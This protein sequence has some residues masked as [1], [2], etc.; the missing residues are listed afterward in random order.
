MSSVSM[1]GMGTG[2]DIYTMAEQMA[3]IQTSAKS[4]QLTQNETEISEEVA[5]LEELSSALNSFYN[6][7]G[8]YSD[9]DLF[10]ALTVQMAEDDKDFIDAKVDSTAVPNTY[11]LEVQQV[12]TQHKVNAISA[13]SNAA[14]VPPGQYTI[15]I[16]GEEMEIDV[17]AGQNSFGEVVDQ[18]NDHPDNPGVTAS[19]VSDGTTSH[20]TLTSD[21][22]GEENAITINGN[23]IPA[24]QELQ[25]AQD[26]EFTV[27]GIPMTSA[28]NTVDTA[29]EGVT[30]D[31]NKVTTDPVKID[32]Q[33]DV[34][35][36]EESIDAIVGAYNDLLGT[37]NSL[38]ESTVDEEGNR[39]ASPLAS[40][41]MMSAIK[42][43]HAYGTSNG[44]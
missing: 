9:P 18:I 2:L 30:L 21:E 39:V 38:T 31:I 35:T 10:G 41:S 23:A 42:K 6:T 13:P 27:D 40:D 29:I 15:D 14:E 4:E 25:K 33:S 16:N 12:A 36:M 19:I 37:I 1:A 44:I 32:I 22:T 5:A 20:L 24:S 26:A 8:L 43:R 11:L 7:L 3:M 34:D 28:S 17:V